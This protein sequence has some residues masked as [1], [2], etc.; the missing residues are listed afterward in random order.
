MVPSPASVPS[1]LGSGMVGPVMRPTGGNFRMSGMAP[2]PSSS[3][4]LNTPGNLQSQPTLSP[5]DNDEQ[6]YRDKVKQLSRFIEPLRRMVSRHGNGGLSI[7]IYIFFFIKKM[8][9]CRI[10]VYRCVITFVR[11][12]V[13]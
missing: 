1:P 11:S 6:A 2:S 9:E 13:R 12:F 5:C 8:Y 7:Y 3:V 4:S 10:Y